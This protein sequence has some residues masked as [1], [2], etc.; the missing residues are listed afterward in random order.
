MKRNPFPQFAALLLLTG[1]AQ[2]GA[3]IPEQADA[4][5]EDA[6]APAADAASTPD[7]TSRL[8]AGG[9]AARYPA[10]VD[11]SA[12]DAARDAPPVMKT[13]DLHQVTVFDNP[14]NLADWPVTT[15]ITEVDFQYMGTD[16]IHVEFSKKDGPGSW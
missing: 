3:P 2:D 12:P 8:D 13:L 14:A 5:V 11:Q 1:C 16:G 7:A 15:A 6:A 9:Y 4:D 10:A